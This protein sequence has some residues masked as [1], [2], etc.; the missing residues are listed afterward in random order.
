MRG[1]RAF[2]HV[3]KRIAKPGETPDLLIERIRAEMQL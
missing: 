3:T 1:R 2:C